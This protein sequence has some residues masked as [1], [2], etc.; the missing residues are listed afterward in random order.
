[1]AETSA[2]FW[3]EQAKESAVNAVR[4]ELSIIDNALNSTDYPPNEGRKKFLES[5]SKRLNMV[6]NFITHCNG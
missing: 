1:M 2:N 6:L 4:T 5:Q 3:F